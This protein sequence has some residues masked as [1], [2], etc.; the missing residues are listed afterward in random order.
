MKATNLI[1]VTGMLVVG[2]LADSPCSGQDSAAGAADQQ[3]PAAFSIDITATDAGTGEPV[4]PL[5]IVPASHSGS[6]SRLT[7][8][9]QYRK[10]YEAAPARFQMQ[11]GWPQT[12]LRIE[13]AGYRPHVT[14]PL[15]REAGQTLQLELE[16]D[17]G[18][19][20]SV[21]TPD[22]QPAVG[23]NVARCTWTNEV[24]V[25]DGKLTFS[26]HGRELGHQ[27]Q[28]GDDGSFRL[29]PEVDEWVLVVAHETG[30]AERTIA[31]FAEQKSITLK[32][33]GRL[34]GTFV[35]NRKPVTD[36]RVQVGAG[37]GDV[38][39]ILHYL[40]GDVRTDADGRF[41]VERL[42]P[43]RLFVSPLFEHEGSQY[44]LLWF[45]GNM[46]I[47]AGETT[48]ITLPRAGQTLTG[49]LAVPPDSGLSFEELQ[50]EMSINLRPPGISGFRDDVA[51]Q[52]AAY[53]AFMQS[54]LGGAFRRERVP[55]HANGRFRIEGLPETHYALSARAWR[56][57]DP[58]PA[59]RGRPLAGYASRVE[60]PLK[61]D[62]APV[63]DLGVI[64]LK[65][66]E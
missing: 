8:Q 37:R 19:A 49:Q 60:V 6:G 38:E 54:D 22:G 26:G 41:V 5:R 4:E 43:V 28:A 50:I 21:L 13:A 34:E 17:A 14:D 23:A 33:W 52:F 53:A 39:V 11:R 18:I 9:S 7:W 35:V 65:L 51:K 55:V 15:P 2:S 66:S 45:S 1:V 10:S 64:T 31:E 56:K 20:G 12:V 46:E 63:H 59:D 62:A 58:D 25:R 44:S 36:Q 16:P 32:P 27:I 40:A 61:T 48:R 42:P 30:Y 57:T 24:T 47:A 3:E 29:P